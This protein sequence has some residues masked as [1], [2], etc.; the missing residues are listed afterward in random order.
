MTLVN[1]DLYHVQ[2]YN[3]RDRNDFLF[4]YIGMFHATLKHLSNIFEATPK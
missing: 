3:E 2:D 1:T 4:H